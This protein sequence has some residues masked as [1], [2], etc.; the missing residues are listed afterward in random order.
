MLIMSHQVHIPLDPITKNH[1]GMAY[2]T[3]ADPENAVTAFESVDKKS[4]QG[5]LLHVLPAIDRKGKITVEEA[6][7]KKSLKEERDAKKKANAGKDFNWG[8]L[9]MNVCNFLYVTIYLVPHIHSL[10]L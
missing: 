9:Y 5:R 6:G 4:F 1:K 8:M 7:K 3:F 2:V 10:F